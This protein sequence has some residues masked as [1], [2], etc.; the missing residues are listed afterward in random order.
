[1]NATLSRL[2]VSPSRNL[3]LVALW[4]LAL[5]VHPLV[6]LDSFL[7]RADL[8][9]WITL[10]A[11]GVGL[12]RGRSLGDPAHPS[13]T[14]RA[15]AWGRTTRRIA[16]ALVPAA[17]ALWFDAGATRDLVLTSAAASLTVVV[18]VLAAIGRVD[19]QTAWRPRGRG[20][21]LAW[22]ARV[23]G[24]IG[25]AVLLGV[26]SAHAEHRILRWMPVSALLGTQMLGIGLV[27]DRLLHR[28]QRAAAGRRDG[29][30]WRPE[31][32]RFAVAAV[33]PSIGLALLLVMQEVLIEPVGF[34]QG[35]VVALHVIA[36][37]A[38]LWPPR[39]PVAVSCVLH[40]VE[41]AA[42]KDPAA[43]GEA[44]GFDRPPIGALRL[45]PLG[46][47]RLRIVHHWLVEVRDPRI[48]ELDDPIRPLWPR[49]AVPLGFHVLGEAAFEPD[50]DTQLP[51]W[52]TITVRLHEHRDVDRL[53]G[54]DVQT[55][56]LAVLRAFPSRHRGGR[57]ALRTYRW[58]PEIP[59]GTLQVV[60]A[61]TERVTFE[62]GDIIVLSTEGVARAFELEIG[63]PIYD[64]GE[65]G[66]QR[67]PQL[68]D[69]VGV[70]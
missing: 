27:G 15:S 23:I 70:S 16:L 29:V 43:R 24:L 48:Q 45:D 18:G 21:L 37:G 44:A 69:Y 38:V 59:P 31:R 22:C 26:W 49:R 36:W 6:P 64:H 17:A 20:A 41:P 46:I 1:V 65:L 19:G 13:L 28:W 68:E 7:A 14:L 9:P 35:A 63:A 2:L 4:F 50:P 3:D 12:L 39:M 56:R 47:K 10:W 5:V 42:G 61:T 8:V 58:D 60:D 51:Q 30:R 67:A 11:C 34:G 40:E 54:G 66:H 32:F 53:A 62:D 57:R 55:R 33:G 25:A 52:S